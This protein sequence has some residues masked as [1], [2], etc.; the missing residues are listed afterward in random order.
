M[1]CPNMGYKDK[2]C[3]G[4]ISKELADALLVIARMMLSNIAATANAAKEPVNKA[5]FLSRVT[6]AKAVPTSP[7]A[8]KSATGTPARK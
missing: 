3:V 6:A 1:N 4:S 2:G 5:S 7:K 8:A